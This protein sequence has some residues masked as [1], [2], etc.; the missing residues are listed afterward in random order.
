MTLFDDSVAR[1]QR[2]FKKYCHYLIEEILKVSFYLALIIPLD[3]RNLG[4]AAMKSQLVR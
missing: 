3:F 2:D 1:R 4:R